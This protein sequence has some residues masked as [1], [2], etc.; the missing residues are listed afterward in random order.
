MKKNFYEITATDLRHNH[1]ISEAHYRN[2]LYNRQLN[3]EVKFVE[4]FL[5]ANAELRDI[6]REI[7]DC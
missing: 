2:Y 1:A 4:P 5:V 7:K 3:E 6:A